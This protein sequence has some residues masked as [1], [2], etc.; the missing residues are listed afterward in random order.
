MS[1][2]GV[3]AIVLAEDTA[4]D[5]RCPEPGTR[6]SILKANEIMIV[7]NFFYMRICFRLIVSKCVQEY[8]YKNVQEYHFLFHVG[9]KGQL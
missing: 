8:S 7:R 9:A 2:S 1:C 5:E 6:G 3:A 4:M